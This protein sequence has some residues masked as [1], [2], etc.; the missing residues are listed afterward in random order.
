MP[1]RSVMCVKSDRRDGDDIRPESLVWFL[2][3]KMPRLEDF[4]EEGFFGYRVGC[5]FKCGNRP[6]CGFFFRRRRAEDSLFKSRRRVEVDHRREPSVYGKCLRL[7]PLHRQHGLSGRASP[8]LASPCEASQGRRTRRRSFQN[9]R[10]SRCAVAP[11]RSRPGKQ[12]VS[13]Q[14]GIHV[15]SLSKL[16]G[17]VRA[18]E[19]DGRARSSANERSSPRQPVE[20][21]ECLS[22][23]SDPLPVSPGLVRQPEKVPR[24]MEQAVRAT[25]TAP[26]GASIPPGDDAARLGDGPV[27]G[28]LNE[29]HPFAQGVEVGRLAL[30]TQ[31]CVDPVGDEHAGGLRKPAADDVHHRGASVRTARR[32]K[33]PLPAVIEVVL[34]QHPMAVWFTFPVISEAQHEAELK[35]RV[36]FSRMRA[37]SAR[38]DASRGMTPVSAN[39]ASKS[40]D[41]PS[42]TSNKM[43]STGRDMDALG[44]R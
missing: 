12:V 36:G 1:L 37:A 23:L 10:E 18:H 35:G 26:S 30:P 3:A 31:P 21:P 34:I 2:P 29:R 14:Q 41:A 25:R 39:G 11:S 22:R 8:C 33:D 40:N 19:G 44:I 32:R 13:Q 16:R 24:G 43:R 38:N 15:D 5:A 20:R 6:R 42:Q 9:R 28:R 7:L 4:A 17:S 27:H